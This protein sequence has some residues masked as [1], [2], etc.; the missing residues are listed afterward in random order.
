MKRAVLVNG[1]SEVL[2]GQC[3]RANGGLWYRSYEEFEACLSLLT[4]GPKLRNKLGESGNRYAT[5]SYTWDRI[6]TKYLE[7]LSS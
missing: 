1:I 7:L 5:D 2:V 4:N 6:E 3:K